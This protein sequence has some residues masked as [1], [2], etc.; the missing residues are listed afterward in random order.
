M[1]FPRVDVR[2]CSKFRRKYVEP[3]KRPKA[4]SEGLQ[5]HYMALLPA[6]FDT[7]LAVWQSAGRYISIFKLDPQLFL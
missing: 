6:S 1:N 7:P 2:F 3:G 5:T 4:F